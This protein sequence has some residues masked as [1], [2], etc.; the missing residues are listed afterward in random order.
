MF[1][2]LPKVWTKNFGLSKESSVAIEIRADGSLLIFPK[3][4]DE[5]NRL[6]KEIVLESSTYVAREMSR[7]FLSG[8]ETVVIFSDKEIEKNVRSEI[9]WFVDG[10][11]NTEIIEEKKQ[12]I[13]V[14]NFGYKKIPTK[15]IIQR[16]LYLICDMF[17]NL[18]ESAMTDVKQNF[19]KLKRFY[20]ILVTHIRTYLRTGIYISEENEHDFTPLEAMDLR[21]FCE[22][23]EDIGTI[24]KNLRL[25]EN[26][27][28]FF[29]EI[30]Q[31]FREVMD[32]YM[33]KDLA[34]AH[35]A[36][37][38]KNEVIKKA[39]SL[40]NKSNYDDKERQW[41]RSTKP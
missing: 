31:Y 20:F 36:W 26:I 33:K 12:R 8:I 1:V 25:N 18:M 17:E 28:D 10:L 6:K 30:Y 7:N 39:R 23:V 37:L 2:S 41:P 24:L 15:K 13:V 14:Q 5:E 38:K 34:L 40:M 27:T 11:P 29:Q 9:N 3:L 4:H 35:E 32:A 19:K 21:M 16:L 22:K